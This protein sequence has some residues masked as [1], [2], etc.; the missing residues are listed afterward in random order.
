[1]KRYLIVHHSATIDTKS[2][3][4]KNIR[5]YHIEHKKWK[6]IG[7]HFGIEQINNSYEILLGRF[8]NEKGA[9]C[10]DLGMNTKAY[11]VCCVGN[12]NYKTPPKI[13]INILVNLCLWLN[14]PTENVLGHGEV[15]AKNGKIDK[16]PCPGRKFDMN[17]LRNKIAKRRGL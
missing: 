14:I 2:L 3:S 4:W 6:N 1:M 9:H 8:A 12:F 15:R 16:W 10:P 17:I 7:Y 11:G 13:V 5:D